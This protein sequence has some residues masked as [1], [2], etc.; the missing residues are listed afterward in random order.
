MNNLI[1][2]SLVFFVYSFGDF[3]ADKTKAFI[4]MILVASVI[5]TISFWYGLPKTIFYDAGLVQFAKLTVCML[6]IHI[7]ST[8]RIRDFINEWRVVVVALSAVLVVAMC[9]FFAGRLFIDSYYALVGAPVLVGG[10]VAYLVM[11]PIG[12]ILSRPDIKV[13]AILI[14]VFHSFV[15]VPIA[16]YFCKKAGEAYAAT[17]G[18]LTDTE[19]AGQEQQAAPKRKVITIPQKFSTPNIILT[20]LA[21]ISYLATVCGEL[22][23]LSF[24]IFGIIFGVIFQE[25]GLLEDNCLVK[26]NGMTFVMAGAIAMVFD[27]L[28][29]TTPAMI[30]GMILPLLM[31]F[32]I[33]VVACVLTAVIAAKAIHMD[34][35]LSIAMAIAAF[36]GFPGTYLIALEVSKACGKTEAEHKKV[37]DYIMPKIVIAGIVSVSIVSGLLAGVMVTW[38]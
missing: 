8:I 24:L 23:S 33:G 20:K 16:S 7:G 22:T 25:I 38:I 18:K 4:S 12:D 29:A 30:A 9:V 28:T 3:I 36:F 6:L 34:W 19:E 17:L 11:S 13:F 31:V 15:G 1:A 35:Q 10:V 32:A 5:F 14:L 21:I 26:A 37:L 27:G 2:L